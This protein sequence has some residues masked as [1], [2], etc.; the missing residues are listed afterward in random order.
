MAYSEKLAD[1]VREIISATHRITDEKKM[2][3]GLCFMVNNKM[4]IGINADRIMV[5]LN[6]GVF[7]EVVEINGCS[8]MEMTGRT[9]KGFVYVSEEVLKTKK[10]LDYWV[11][12]ALDYNKD[13][14]ESKKKPAK[15]K[16]KKKKL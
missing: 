5:R 13:A 14:P 12:L 9:M 7:D 2:F 11:Q 3:S 8:P 4:C 10:Q 6:P 16:A 1:R 15:K